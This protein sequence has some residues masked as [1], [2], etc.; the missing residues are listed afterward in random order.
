MT[1]REEREQAFA[2]LF[3]RQ[4]NQESIEHLIENAGL[5]RDCEVSKFTRRVALGV[6][7]H[8]DTI[9][10]LIAANLRGWTFQRLSRVTVALLQLAIY[11][12]QYEKEIPLKVS[13]NEAVELAKEY[14]GA[15]DAAYINGVLGGVAKGLEKMRN[16]LGLDT[17]NYTTSVAL[18]SGGEICQEKKLLPVKEGQ[19]GLR[20]SDAVFHHVQQLPTVAEPL[21][22]HCAPLSAIGVSARPRDCEGSYMPCFTVGAGFGKSLSDVL[23]VPLYEFSHQAGHIAAALYSCGR[24]DL[25]ERPFLAYHVSGG[26]TE[27]VLV[28]P[29]S[30][31]ILT[32]EIISQSIDLKG[33]QA[34]D[35]V[36]VMLGL[37]FPAGRELEKLALQCTERIKVKPTMKG[38]D[39]CLSGIENQ[40]RA[41]MEKG[42]PK[43][44]I[45]RYCLESLGAALSQSCKQLLARLGDLPVVFAGGVMSNT[46]LRERLTKQFGAFF[47]EPEFA[48]DN[49]AGIAVLTALKH[50]E[51]LW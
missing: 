43:E 44:M 48:R 27:A 39:F 16:F 35:R 11:E 36:G 29:D 15:E 23:G 24:L 49:A 9:N 18:F 50:G 30:E 19:L 5:A 2:L 12:M 41:M 34:I 46:I 17:S 25:I 31:R 33:G 13:I 8:E 22:K 42:T 38:D 51:S 26:T 47:A 7:Q 40:C 4:M 3:E 1:R 14:G 28:R 21:L 32:E 20:Q 37:R 10:D 6:E 45:A